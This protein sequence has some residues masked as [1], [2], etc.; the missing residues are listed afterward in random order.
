MSEI[1]EERIVVYIDILGWSQAC[2]HDQEVRLVNAVKLIHD[3]AKD[4]SAFTKERIGELTK[5]IGGQKN[6]L[7]ETIQ[8]GAFSDN[9]IISMPVAHGFRAL[10]SA[11]NIVIGLLQQGFL[12]RGGVAVGKLHHRDNIVFGPALIKAVEIEKQAYF[13]RVICD[14]AVVQLLQGQEDNVVEYVL[15][16]AFG[17]KIVNPFVPVAKLQGQ[18]IREFHNEVWHIPEIEALIEKRTIQLTSE[19]NSRHSEKWRY[20]RTTLT[21]MLK[22]L[23][24]PGRF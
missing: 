22:V 20:M 18:T 15:T 2:L 16:D 24:E 19:G 1:Y 14:D 4:Y 21:S 6:V 23:D 8:V 13:P 10:Q 7:Y 9:I 17:R 12:T 11:G 5:R 3:T